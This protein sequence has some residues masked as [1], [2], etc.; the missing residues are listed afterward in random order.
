MKLSPA[1]HQTGRGNGPELIA[2]IEV[3]RSYRRVENNN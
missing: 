3:R 1:L 2:Y